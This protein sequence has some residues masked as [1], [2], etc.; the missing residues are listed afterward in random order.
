[1]PTAASYAIHILLL[2]PDGLPA[3]S[4]AIAINPNTV[5]GLFAHG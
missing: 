5:L 1:M 3:L 4:V 2:H